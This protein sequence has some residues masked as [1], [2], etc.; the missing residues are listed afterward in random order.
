MMDWLDD[1]AG[2]DELIEALER[3][4]DPEP[5]TLAEIDAA[6]NRCHNL[7]AMEYQARCA[8]AARVL[9][10]RL[11]DSVPLVD[12]RRF[13]RGVRHVEGWDD[14]LAIPIDDRDETDVYLI[15]W[16]CEVDVN[17]QIINTM[18]G[19]LRRIMHSDG[20]PDIEAARAQVECGEDAPHP[21]RFYLESRG[22]DL[23][24]PP[25]WAS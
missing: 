18:R 1:T 22:V 13:R 4:D 15:D 14:L 20:T 19:A 7:P 17:E 6:R 21:A 5:I 24:A 2:A 9:R 23:P 11:S 16:V 25:G 3:W 10:A 12:L 8:L